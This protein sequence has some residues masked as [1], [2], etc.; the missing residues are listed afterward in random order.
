MNKILRFSMLCLMAVFFGGS[1]FA[2]EHTVWEEDWNSS[3]NG[4]K[5]EDVSNSNATYEGDNGVYIKLYPNA[6]DATNL[7]LLV[8]KKSR[9]LSFTAN[10]A[11]NGEKNLSLTFTV[12]KNIEVT[13]ST[14][15]ASLTKIDNSNYTITVPEGTNTLSLTFT[16]AVDQNA[17]LDDIKLTS[18]DGEVNPDAL[19]APTITGDTSFEESTTVT[20]TTTEEGATILYT[21][22]GD[23]PTTAGQTYTAP[24]T[25]NATTTVKAV[26]KKG[27]K[28]SPVASKT[29]TKVEF[30][31]V[32][33]IAAFNALANN[34]TNVVLTLTNAK[35][36]AYGNNSAV[37]NDGTAGTELYN[38]TAVTMKQGDIL[39]GTVTGTKADYKGITEMTNITENTLVVTEG[40]VVPTVA[41]VAEV[42]DAEIFGALYKLENVQVVKDGKN[43]YMKDGDVQM[44]VYNS[45]NIDGITLAEGQFNIEGVVGAYNSNKQFLPTKFE[46]YVSPSDVPA[47]TISGDESFE[48]QTTITITTD[49][50]GGVIY[51]TTD[52]TD[53]ASSGTRQDYG[54]PFVITETTTVKACVE[55]EDG[56]LSSTVSK[57][58]TKVSANSAA[59]IAAFNALADKTT[60]VVLTLTNAQVLAKGGNYTIVADATAGTEFFRVTTPEL[61]AGDILNGTITGTKDSY[62][63]VPELTSVSANTLVITEGTVTA[64]AAD[65]AT[66]AEAPIFAKL[67]KLENVAISGVN[68]K[69]ATMTQNNAT[70][71]LY[72]QFNGVTLA[73]GNYNIEGVVG[74]YGET[75]QFW[76]T[77][78]EKNLGD[79]Q[80]PALSFAEASYTAILGE[81][82]T[83]PAL[84]NEKNVAVEWT[85]TNEAVAT[86]NENGVVTILAA[87]TTTIT[88]TSAETDEF[89]ASSASYTLK[90]TDPAIAE[91]GTESSPYFVSDVIALAPE[92]SSAAAGAERTWTMGYIVGYIDGTSISAARFDAEPSANTENPVKTNLLL[93][94]NANETDI[95][96]CIPVNLPTGSIREGLNLQDN[97][98]NLGK[99][100][101]ICGHVLKYFGVSG[102]KN[103][104]SFKMVTDGINATTVATSN[105]DAPLYNLAG[106]RVG[107]GFKG[108]VLKNGKKIVIK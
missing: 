103:V 94:D 92:S 85:S 3:T 50:E 25:V 30:S 6:N 53:P 98:S 77:K 57:T 102:I 28:F 58:F 42:A 51:Y 15:G 12:N 39:N 72:N 20:I 78:F 29:F 84:V 82:F 105:A 40:T 9:S 44:Q 23:N 10:V 89:V 33:T 37:I 71:P 96:K 70:M 7:E 36:L 54:A 4:T 65:V 24:F 79:K 101:I 67:Y 5:V 14:T 21:V 81:A 95:A 46:A 32:T 74:I 88:A 59:N 68:R 41:T 76:P 86:V 26:V 48:E 97:P 91:R 22:N 13:S 38:F 45:L 100:V 107:K 31:G 93:A 56:D 73:E 43:Y 11:L 16:T 69:N 83:S 47:P 64:T 75:K 1:M 80:D 27:D 17:R 61:K 35:V 52:G 90:V 62:N 106:Q 66:V 60:N 18:E 19:S 2:D 55:N 49:V 63:G 87:G 8:P 108:I 104:N 34:T 99:Q